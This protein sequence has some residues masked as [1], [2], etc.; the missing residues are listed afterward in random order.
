M[1]CGGV[2]QP[3]AW[4]LGTTKVRQVSASV[5]TTGALSHGSA[6]RQ[7]Q[8]LGAIGLAAALALFIELLMQM[9]PFQDEFGSRGDEARLTVNS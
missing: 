5:S 1:A 4:S 2:S 7:R 8:R 6:H 3:A 9:Q